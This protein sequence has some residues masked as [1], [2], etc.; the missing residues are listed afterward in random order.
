[1]SSGQRSALIAL[2]AVGLSL[3]AAWA[4]AQQKHVQCTPSAEQIAVKKASGSSRRRTKRQK[5]TRPEMRDAENSEPQH[6][7]VQKATEA[8]CAAAELI[9]ETGK[10]PAE[11]ADDEHSG[12]PMVTAAAV[13]IQALDQR[14]LE[15]QIN[16]LPHEVEAASITGHSPA[17]TCTQMV[18]PTND[19]PVSTEHGEW[20]AVERRQRRR[21]RREGTSPAA[22][23]VE[24]D[25]QVPPTAEPHSQPS[26]SA[27]LESMP[28]GQASTREPIVHAA[29]HTELAVADDVPAASSSEPS[30][31]GSIN[32][33]SKRRQRK[34]KRVTSTTHNTDMNSEP[35]S[36][37][38]DEQLPPLPWTTSRSEQCTRDVDEST[39]AIV[40]T[41][42][43]DPIMECP[44]QVQ[45]MAEWVEV[46]R[47]RGKRPASE[48]EPRSSH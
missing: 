20:I 42:L 34:K 29:V 5:S 9:E 4:W 35:S 21:G 24:E 36:L 45:P 6:M 16:A 3:G 48:N 11:Q 30:P 37:S 46:K 32:K 26:P 39:A 43:A 2:G 38:G 12:S 44:R 40:T 10:T 7:A 18:P 22:P 17:E 41:E 25:F 27:A 8:E 15:L 19:S 47:R 1:M 31:E 13:G 14:Q 23:T 28:A 33:A